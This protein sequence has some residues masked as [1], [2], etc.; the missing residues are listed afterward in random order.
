MYT[1]VVRVKRR[2][3]PDVTLGTAEEVRRL[4]IEAGV[5]VSR[6]WLLER[7]ARRGHSTTRQRLNRA[8]DFFIKLEVAF[9][10][11][12]GIQWTDSGSPSL[13]RARAIGREFRP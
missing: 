13:A 3:G 11:S 4:L 1:P 10:G 6:N 2:N 9:E 5:P 8:I 12:K 7:L